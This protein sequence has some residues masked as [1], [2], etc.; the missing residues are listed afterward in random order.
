MFNLKPLVDVMN[1]KWH[2]SRIQNS[3]KLPKLG[4][5]KKSRREKMYLATY[6]SRF[7]Q[8]FLNYKNKLYIVK[9]NIFRTTKVFRCTTKWIQA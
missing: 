7:C 9:Y 5:F 6:E 2:L 1:S 8:Y 3:L 4:Q